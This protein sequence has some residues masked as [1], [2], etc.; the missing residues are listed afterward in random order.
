MSGN[1]PFRVDGRGLVDRTRRLGFTFDG[2]RLEGFSGDTLA[3][4]LLGAGVR[5]VGRSFKYHRPRGILTAGSEEPNALVTLGDGAR[6][7]PN[8]RATMVRLVEGL[9][10]RSQ[11]AWPSLGFDLLSFVTGP[12]GRF[13][14]AGFY[15]KVFK[16][17]ASWWEPV[18]ERVIRRA[19]GL[20]GAPDGRD[21]DRYDR[22]FGFADVLVVGAGPAGLAAVAT[23]AA[24]GLSVTLADEADRPG[25]MLLAESGPI[26]GEAPAAAVDRRIAELASAGARV[27]AATTA[28]GL[29]DGGVVGLVERTAPGAVAREIHHVL[30]TRAVVLATG[31]IEQPLVFGDNDRPGH[32]TAQAARTYLNRFG[33]AVGRRVVLATAT[34]AAYAAAFDLVEAGVAVPV[35][36][37]RR[38]APGPGLAERARALGIAVRT[39]TAVHAIAGR[40]L[41]EGVRIGPLDGP[42]ATIDCD[43]VIS[44]AGFAP[45]IHLAAQGRDRPVFDPVTGSFRLAERGGPLFVAGG[46]DGRGGRVAAEADGVA[47]AERVAAFLGRGSGRAVPARPAPTPGEAP[48]PPPSAKGAFLDFQNDVKVSDVELAARE[49]Y[50][51]V[52]HMKRY[53]TL[54]M[55]IDQGKTANLAAIATLAAARGLAPEAV[56]TTLYRPPYTPVSL[57]A[58][59]GRQVGTHLRPTALVALHDLHAAEGAV[60]IRTGAW[61]RPHHYP[62]PGEGLA[63][64]A[65]REARAVREGVGVCDVS[66]LGK[67][68][69]EGPDAV[70]FLERIYAN[71]IGTLQPGRA[72][73][74]VMLRDD[75][76]V[77]DDGIVC[78]ID[79]TRFYLTTT[80]AKAAE[81]ELV[82]AKR[83]QIDWP[84]LEVAVTPATV[85]FAALAVTGPKAREVVAGLLGEVVDLSDAAMPHM[86][87]VT[88]TSRGGIPLR[89]L[90]VSF[91]GERGWELHVD[92]TRAAALFSE[93][94]QAGAPYGLVLFGLEALDT[95]RLEKGY[96]AGAEIDGRTTLADLGLAR[97]AKPGF[98]HAGAVSALRE[99]LAD[100]KRPSLVGLVAV[101]PT[102]TFAAGAHLVDGAD[103]EKPGCS[104]GFVTS[105]A[106]SPTLGRTIALGLLEE[107]A[108]RIGG[109]VHASDPLNGTH[110]ELEVR[111]PVFH[112]PEGG[113]VRG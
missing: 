49:G 58:F 42:T 69:V 27:L 110:V 83:L 31:A 32:F 109:R 77:F 93:L 97:L 85:R 35:I 40:G 10:V 94:G 103:P 4:A 112:D 89:L 47:V 15:Y 87:H 108:R 71:R 16:W 17:P 5:V 20:G 52:E 53:T 102:Q 80:T 55:A 43:A 73:Y 33:V 7:D 84:D 54:G 91:T 21:P 78:R 28:Y 45:A 6:R 2:R 30:R 38:A 11:N 88:V 113:R 98:V 25:G 9:E 96:P 56:G 36:A 13:L 67:F 14:P 12:F 76:H 29:F 70:E 46:A 48:P 111:H 63:A 65:L 64:A 57:G 106:T 1:G 59:A 95:L 82:F 51:S 99:G 39:D 86:S 92:T 3:S 81:I 66:T 26:D 74:A 79:E 18:Y 107:G 44:S 41:V 104:L 22:E 75:G 101:D 61:L 62:R 50:V 23:L 24:A 37:E 100:P 8:A 72:R 19:A 60:F 34:D 105:T 68:F 90:R